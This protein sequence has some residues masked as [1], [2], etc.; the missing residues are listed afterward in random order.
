MLI[1]HEV[2]EDGWRL[3]NYFVDELNALLAVAKTKEAAVQ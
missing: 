2:L 3:F 1:D